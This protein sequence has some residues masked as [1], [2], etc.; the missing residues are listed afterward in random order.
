MIQKTFLDP[1]ELSPED[2]ETLFFHA[3]SRIH[4][5]RLPDIDVE[6]LESCSCTSKTIF[7]CGCKC[8]FFKKEQKC[9]TQLKS[10]K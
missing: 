6:E 2:V 3:R 4:R 10:K 9:N 7:D 5:G 1:T 8:G